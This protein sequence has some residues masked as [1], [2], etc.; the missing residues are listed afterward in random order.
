MTCPAE[1]QII[2]ENKL[3]IYKKAREEY[4]VDIKTVWGVYF[5]ATGTTKKV[6]SCVAKAA[7][8]QLG[9]EYKPYSFSLPQARG[10][11]LAFS[12]QDLV[13]LGVPVYAG[14][15]PNKL[16]PYLQEMLAGN[17]ALAVP[18][19]LFGNRHFDDALIELQTLMQ[20]NGFCTIAAGAFV[21][22]HSFST[23]LAANRPNKEDM[24]LAAKLGSAA[25]EKARQLMVSPVHPVKV[26]GQ[27]PLRPYYKPRNRSG[28]A[29]NILKV[30]PKTH[31]EKCTGCGLCASVCTMGAIAPEDVSQ[32]PGIC[33]KCCACI[34]S[35]PTQAKY[36]DD[37]GFLYHLQE[38]EE[39]YRRP[40]AVELFL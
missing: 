24:A 26:A 16:L 5:S 39:M 2:Y 9:A 11:A 19:V 31:T 10:Q 33:I 20:Q 40:A 17:G 8:E 13:L 22:E 1:S 34:K 14:R 18:I 32:V 12:P 4:A 25:A 3:V 28:E 23:V 6:V 38:L 7:A 36:F 21:G 15:V 27:Q 35:C 29:I 30:K 37:E